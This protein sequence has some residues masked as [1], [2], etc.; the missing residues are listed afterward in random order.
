MSSHKDLI[1]VALEL[2]V[3]VESKKKEVLAAKDKDIKQ[4]AE[5][6]KFERYC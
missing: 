6:V 5:L 4:K 1:V 2:Q 3:A